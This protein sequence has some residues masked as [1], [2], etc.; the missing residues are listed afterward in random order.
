MKSSP[1]DVLLGFERFILNLL[2]RLPVILIFWA[3]VG[4]KRTGAQSK[5]V[6]Q[7]E[8]NY[9]E[10]KAL[11]L[12]HCEAMIDLVSRRLSQVNYAC[13]RHGVYNVVLG[14][15]SNVPDAVQYSGPPD[16]G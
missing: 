16:V 13:I 9:S 15:V 6:Q 1:H 10:E 12:I 5:S 8:P 7:P 3:F 14:Y 4:L 2:N 11:L